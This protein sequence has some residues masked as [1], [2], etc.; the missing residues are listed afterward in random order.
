MATRSVLIF[1]DWFVP[2]YKAGGPIQSVFNITA[3]LGRDFDLSIVTSDR[4]LGDTKAFSG[5]ALNTWIQTDNYRVIYLDSAH[6]TSQVYKDLLKERSYQV[7]YVNSLFSLKF[8]LLPLWLL[9]DQ[10]IK[11]VLAPRGMLGTG[12]LRIKSLKKQLFLYLFKGFKLHKKITWHA[13]SPVEA[14]EIKDHFGPEVRIQIAQNLSAPMPLSLPVK[15]KEPHQ[16]RLFFLSRISKKKN[17]TAA[18]SILQNTAPNHHITFS[19][20]GAVE[21]GDY[22]SDCK[23]MI[24]L[25]PKHI[26]VITLGAVPH[27]DLSEILQKQHLL[28]LPTQHENFG[29]VIMESWQ[30]G[31]PVLISD[32]TPWKNLERDKRGVDIALK[33]PDKFVQA[34]NDFAAMD[35]SEFSEWSKASYQFAKAHSEDPSLLEAS[36]N[37]FAVHQ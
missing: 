11:K 27:A 31:C 26:E 9:R 8:A 20:I 34:I 25:L 5:L 13:T 17:L 15:P 22:Y 35:Q 6:Q 32:Q 28:L 7:I 30:Q 18:L 16:L 24:A 23:A 37:L 3:Y 29:H 10:P 14:E 21:D 33:H 1:I 4:D 19:I 2:A 36:R 12:A